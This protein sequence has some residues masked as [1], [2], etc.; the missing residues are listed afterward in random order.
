MTAVVRRD[1][2]YGAEVELGTSRQSARP[3]MQPAWHRS[4]FHI[5]VIGITGSVGKTTTKEMVASVLS[6]R[7]NTHKTQKNF[8]NE[9]GVPQT[10]LR[11][12][13]ANEVSVVEKFPYDETTE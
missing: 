3:F 7:F 4:R 5:P 2:P 8:N 12:D 1:C 11:L 13:D 10:L 9:L 6:E